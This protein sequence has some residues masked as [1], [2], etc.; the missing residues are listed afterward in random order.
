MSHTSN[1]A[2]PPLQA[3]APAQAA[4]S[5]TVI[6]KSVASA[7]TPRGG[8]LSSYFASLDFSNVTVADCVVTVFSQVL[9]PFDSLRNLSPFAAGGGGGLFI[10]GGGA[11]FRNG[12]KARPTTRQRQGGGHVRKAPPLR[13]LRCAL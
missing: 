10:Y 13:H 4:L 2:S 9:G 7:Y 12:T 6:S 8:G 11:R 1:A 5:D 3:D